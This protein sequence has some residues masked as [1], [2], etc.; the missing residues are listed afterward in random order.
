MRRLVGWCGRW[1]PVV[2]GEKVNLVFRQ[3]PVEMAAV[4]M[5]VVAELLEAAEG[6]KSGGRLGDVVCR[7]WVDRVWPW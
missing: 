6:E 7:D 4:M 5:A 3:M 1:S 2:R